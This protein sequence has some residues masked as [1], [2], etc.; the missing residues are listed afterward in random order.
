MNR[1]LQI[2]SYHLEGWGERNYGDVESGLCG[3]LQRVV[4]VNP[5][6]EE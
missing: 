6:K 5:G 4:R 2:R 1:I 3:K